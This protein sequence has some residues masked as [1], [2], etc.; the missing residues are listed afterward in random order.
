MVL[1]IRYSIR[2]KKRC[3][4]IDQLLIYF[5][6]FI[7]PFAEQSSAITNLTQALNSVKWEPAHHSAFEYLKS[8]LR[9]A[10][11]LHSVNFCT[12]FGLLVDASAMTVGCCSIQR[13]DGSVERPLA[14]A[15]LKLS[16]A[17]SRWATIEHEAYEVILALKKFRSWIFGSKVTGFRTIIHHHTLLK[18]HRDVLGLLD[19]TW[20]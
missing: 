11:I 8:D 15:S 7:P 9:N 12:D 14:F 13:T 16:H 20:H 17:Q 10:V 3:N 6:S 19:G 2:D 4:A 1:R 5:R 18:Q